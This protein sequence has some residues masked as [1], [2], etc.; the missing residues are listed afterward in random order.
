MNEVKKED[1]DIH[2]KYPN[3]I[4]VKKSDMQSKIEMDSKKTYSHPLKLR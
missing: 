3:T 4:K 1:N 2:I